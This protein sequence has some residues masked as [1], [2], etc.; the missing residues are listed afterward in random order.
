[1]RRIKKLREKEYGRRS[2]R[3]GGIDDAGGSDE[4]QKPSLWSYV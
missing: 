2:K 1:M 4:R 3:G